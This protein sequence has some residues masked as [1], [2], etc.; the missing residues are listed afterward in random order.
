MIDVVLAHD[1][2]AIKELTRYLKIGCVNLEGFGGPP[3]CVEGEP[4]G[5]PI[6]VVPILGPEGYHM[7]AAE[8]ESWPEPDVLGLLAVYRTSAETWSDPS[9]PAGDYGLVFLLPGGIELLTL[10]ISGGEIIRF[11]YGFEGISTT[12]LEIKA[13][14]ILLPLSFQPIPTPVAWGRFSDPQSRFTFLYPPLLELTTEE[15]QESWILGDRIKIEVLPFENSW[16]TCFYSSLGDCPFVEGDEIVDV[17]GVEARRVSGYIG[18]VGGN[19]PQEFIT[20]IFTLGDQALVITVYALPFNTKS[21]D[22]D[23]IWPLQGM[24]LE[25]FERTVETVQ[26]FP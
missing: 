25:L 17:N 24:E 11:D 1:F 18:A 6:E 14:E 2:P 9:Y 20:Y 12:D 10:Q 19:I 21:V 4:E 13:Q 16:I 3:H 26:L 23:Q 8:Y 22:I 7:R 5:T 15:S